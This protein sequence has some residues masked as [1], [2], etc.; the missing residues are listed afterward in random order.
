MA[1]EV[2]VELSL[3]VE[4][5]REQE[6][7]D[8]YLAAFGAEQVEQYRPGGV[9]LAVELRLGSM[10][11]TVAGS[12][13]KREKEPSHGGPFSPG[14]AGAVSAV[15]RLVVSNL[16]SVVQKA[17]AA[18]ARLRNP[19]QLDDTERRVASVFDPFGHIWGLVEQRPEQA[20]Q[21]A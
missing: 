6:A 21:A 4:H 5:G 11:L 8:F 3:F 13:P 7:A 2:G 18:G 16:D 15:P 9:L 19:I 14:G 17:I 20:R 12:N 1:D 10:S